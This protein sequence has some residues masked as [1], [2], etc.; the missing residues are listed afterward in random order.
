MSLDTLDRLHKS[1]VAPPRFKLRREWRYRII[2]IENW[3]AQR[4]AAEAER[5]RLASKR[6]KRA[7]ESATASVEN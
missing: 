2:D 5:E 3:L 6:D 1:G 7:A 4:V